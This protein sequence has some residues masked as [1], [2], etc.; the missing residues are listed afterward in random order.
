MPTLAS[1][2]IPTP[3]SWDEFEDIALSAAKL[4]WGSANFYRHGRTGQRQ[5][6]VDIFGTPDDGLQRGLQGKNTIGGLDKPTILKEVAAAETFQPPIEELYIITTAKRDAPLQKAIRELSIQRKKAGKFAV[7]ILFWDDI[8]QDLAVDPAVFRKHYPELAGPG[9]DLVKEHDKALADELGRLLSSKG[10]IGFLD[11]NNM[12]GFSFPYERFEPLRNF[13]YDW[14]KPEKEFLS[15]TL[16]NAKMALWHK[17]DAYFDLLAT[18]TF[19]TSNPDFHSVPSEWEH[20]QPERFRKVVKQFHALAKEIV[21]LHA[22]FTRT[23]KAELIG[24]VRKG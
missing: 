9:P 15:P 4:R 20:Q 17:A 10:V 16:E 11:Q 23:A 5:D 6:G 24:K 7:A 3:K 2:N 18:E 8:V 14:D 22:A 12:A 13:V 21:G 1:S 19:P